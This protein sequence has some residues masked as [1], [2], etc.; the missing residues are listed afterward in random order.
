MSNRTHALT[1]ELYH[2]LLDVSLREPEVMRRLREETAAHP[3]AAM[4]TAPEQGQFMALLIRLMG[5][6][7]TLEI[8]V[9]TGYSALAVALALPPDGQIIACDVSEDY[10]AMARRY[11]QEAGVADKIDLRLAP[12]IETLDALLADGQAAFAES[13][14]IQDALPDYYAAEDILCEDVPVMPI[15]F[16]KTQSVWAEG[17]DN[18]VVDSFRDLDYTRVTSDD[19]TLT[20]QVSEPE[21]L[22]PTTTNESEG[23]A[24]LKALFTGLVGFDAE[25]SEQFNA[26]AE[27]ITTDDGGT[28]WTVVLKDGW[29]F[30]N[31]EPVTADS[32]INAWN[33]GAVGANGQQNNSFYSSIVG[34][35]ELNPES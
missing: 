27:S 23:I 28:T 22:M 4:Q 25:T 13:G 5:A 30:H 6:R 9:F 33:F 35:P 12:A 7:K 18:V 20:H 19:G 15:Y 31:G 32:Y 8:G 34:Y 21:H 11:W 1:D 17:I 3:R 26:H 16:G 24:V 2:Y 10:T 29:T 14:D